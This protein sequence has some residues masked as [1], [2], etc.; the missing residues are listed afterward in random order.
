MFFWWF[1]FLQV[2]ELDF[3]LNCAPQGMLYA[4]ALEWTDAWVQ[5]YVHACKFTWLC[6]SP[7]IYHRHHRII[8]V[9]ALETDGHWVWLYNMYGSLQQHATLC[10][11]LHTVGYLRSSLQTVTIIVLDTSPIDSLYISVIVNANSVDDRLSFSMFYLRERERE[12][13]GVDCLWPWFF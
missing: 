1:P 5:K 13:I 4:E 6:I 12:S 3:N 9:G 2:L 7:S 8:K 10:T 11:R